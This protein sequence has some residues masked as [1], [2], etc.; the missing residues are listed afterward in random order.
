[1]KETFRCISNKSIGEPRQENA[2]NE[3][4]GNGS[5]MT[6]EEPSSLISRRHRLRRRCALVPVEIVISRFPVEG[7]FFICPESRGQAVTQGGQAA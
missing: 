5:S 6:G 4:A 1:M 3:K 7:G 2:G